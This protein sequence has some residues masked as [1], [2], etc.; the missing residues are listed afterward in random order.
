MDQ[1][2]WDIVF[3]FFIKIL[4]YLLVTF[5]YVIGS[6]LVGTIIGIAIAAC[7]LS[8]KKVLQAIGSIYISVMRCVPSIVLLFLIY[9]G[10]PMVLEEQFGILMG[11]SD[12]IV[13]VIIT[14]SLLLGAS[15]S[16]I[17]RTAYLTVPKGQ[18]EAALM[19]GL[20]P[21]ASFMR[22]VLPQA[23]RVALPNYGNIF[24]FMM[25]EG[26]LAYTIGLQDVLGRGFYLNGLRA[27]VF[28]IETYLALT[29]I[30]WPCTFLLEKLFA[31]IE[32]TMKYRKM[33]TGKKERLVK[34]SV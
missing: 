4:P 29:L 15:I 25:K 8:N 9:Y 5:E 26:A 22:I 1:F 11:D 17:L 28:A 34:Q 16:E 23:F 6:V 32:N 27:N 10:L 7:R 30:Y 19:V 18:Y 33:K 31:H 13:Y 3:E 21:F 12:T 20:T 24:I 2:R 14:F